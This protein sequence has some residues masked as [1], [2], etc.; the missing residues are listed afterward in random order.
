M[1]C[2]FFLSRGVYN[3]R[4]HTLQDYN[5]IVMDVSD[6]DYLESWMS[7]DRIYMFSL[8]NLKND[9]PNAM[10][11]YDFMIDPI[12][13]KG[14]QLVDA[15]RF[16]IQI[17]YDDN[18]DFLVFENVIEAWKF[19]NYIGTLYLNATEEQ[20]SLC[21]DIKINLRILFDETRFN[22]MENIFMVIIDNY[23][24]NYNKRLAERNKTPIDESQVNFKAIN[25]LY[26]L[27]LRAYYSLNDFPSHVKKLRIF[28]NRFHE[29]YIEHMREVLKNSYSEVI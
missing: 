6:A 12:K 9:V 24:H 19:Y 13:I 1:F 29:I 17:D 28:I 21:Y 27:F 4:K 8:K 14:I 18:V 23:S 10:I 15:E 3:L 16:C 22:S 5:D 26:E 2:L 11:P 20:N 25:N 7:F